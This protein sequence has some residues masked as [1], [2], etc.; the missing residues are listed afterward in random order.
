MMVIETLHE[1]VHRYKTIYIIV[2]SKHINSEHNLNYTVEY[3]NNFIKVY[4]DANVV[5]IDENTTFFG[6]ILN[7]IRNL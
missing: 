6:N 1:Y 4:G 3:A 7:I 2:S 5:G